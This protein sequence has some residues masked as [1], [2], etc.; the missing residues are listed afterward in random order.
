MIHLLLNINLLPIFLVRAFV[1]PARPQ[2]CEE[3]SSIEIRRASSTGR[4]HRRR[5]KEQLKVQ[6]KPNLSLRRQGSSG[7][8]SPYLARRY[9]NFTRHNVSEG[10]PIQTQNKAI[11]CTQNP[12]QTQNKPN[13][14]LR[15]QGSSL[16]S[17]SGYFPSS[18]PRPAPP[19]IRWSSRQKPACG[20]T[21]FSKAKEKAK[22]YKNPQFPYQN[23]VVS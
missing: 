19:K 4:E 22:K 2:A 1:R 23:Q 8:I 12:P 5:T 9:K 20:I 16:R 10:G 15:R 21:K 14:S 6:N 13:L 11:F 17:K 18:F 3:R 7:T